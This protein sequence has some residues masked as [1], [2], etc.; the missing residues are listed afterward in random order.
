MEFAMILSGD[1]AP[2]PAPRIK[3]RHS[4]TGIGTYEPA[5]GDIWIPDSDSIRA[6]MPKRLAKYLRQ[7]QLS[8]WHSD[9][10]R[11]EGGR[12]IGGLPYIDITDGRGRRIATAYFAPVLADS[13]RTL[14]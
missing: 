7:G 5:S 2:T 12:H 6:A 14:P 1:N 8:A 13:A 9:N 10:A 3:G 4:V 11:I